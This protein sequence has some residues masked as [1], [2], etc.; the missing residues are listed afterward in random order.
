MCVLEFLLLLGSFTWY[1]FFI[2]CF[3]VPADGVILQWTLSYF[4][5]TRAQQVL[6]FAIF[7]FSWPFWQLPCWS[8]TEVSGEIGWALVTT[9]KPL[10]SP[11]AWWENLWEQSGQTGWR[12][13]SHPPVPSAIYQTEVPS[14]QEFHTLLTMWLLSA[15][16]PAPITTGSSSLPS[17][18][19]LS[20]C[21]SLS[22]FSLI[23]QGGSS[24]SVVKRK[25]R[26]WMLKPRVVGR[27]GMCGKGVALFSRCSVG[28]AGG[29]RWVLKAEKNYHSWILRERK[30]TNAIS[31]GFSMM[32]VLQIS[33]KTF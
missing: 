24:W 23:L 33:W 9:D 2:C 14:K 11:W 27:S 7:F 25:D 4:C 5:S 10:L 19:C 16:A 17:L 22:A 1:I 32:Y 3:S 26:I 20:L 28:L 6:L 30:Q 18:P 12:A 13:S 15:A 31:L 8:P 21:L 29:G